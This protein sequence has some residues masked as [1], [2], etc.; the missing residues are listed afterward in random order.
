[1][2]SINGSKD[3]MLEVIDEEEAKQEQKEANESRREPVAGPVNNT[4]LTGA[5]IDE[6]VPGTSA[7]AELPD[8]SFSAV[9]TDAD[10]DA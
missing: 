3:I 4:G 2:I 9:E 5:P 8:L 6:E 7:P 1:V 10:P